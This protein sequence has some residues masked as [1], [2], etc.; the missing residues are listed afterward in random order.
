M[1]YIKSSIGRLVARLPAHQAIT[2]PE[3]MAAFQEQSGEEK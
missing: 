3:L 2:Q 1:Y